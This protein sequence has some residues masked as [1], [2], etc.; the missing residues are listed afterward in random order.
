MV[1]Y[2]KQFNTHSEYNTY[3]TGST[4]ILPNVSYCENN[5]EVHFNPVSEPIVIAKYNVTARPGDATKIC[6][7]TSSFSEIEI[8]E[9]VQPNVVTSYTFDSTG[10]H[11]VKY[12]LLDSTSIGSQAFQNCSKLT[13]IDIPSSVTSIGDA[14]FQG[15]DSLTSINIPSSVTSIGN[16]AFQGCSSLTSVTIPNSV[17]SIGNEAFD[18][19]SGL[20]SINIPSS[21]TNIADYAF[22]GCSGLISISVESGNTVYDSRGNCNAIIET[23]TNTLLCGCQNTI[24]PSSVT[25]IGNNAFRNCT[26][27][28]NINIPSGVTG[29]GIGTFFNCSGLTS[30]NISS[31]VT[32]IGNNAFRNCTGLTNINIPSGVTSIGNNAFYGCASIE[33]ITSQAPTAP[34]IQT[35]TFR[36]VKTD[37]TLYVPAGSTGYDVWMGTGDYYLG[38]LNWTKVEQ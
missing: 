11:I 35:S 36:L 15:C 7:S 31:S 29:I 22:S 8:D 3:I 6:Y 21:V 9:V 34:T 27:L 19:C 25:S 38:S 13:S 5:N 24:I 14:A 2:A 20:T 23:A 18:V 10:E 12:T 28:T 17:T 26:G 16:N 30:I 1:K 37:G 32:S 4:K 33:S